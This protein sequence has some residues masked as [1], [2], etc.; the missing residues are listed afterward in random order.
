MAP[1]APSGTD[2]IAAVATPPGRGGVGVIRVSGPQSRAVAERLFVSPR[3]DFTGLRPYRLHHGTLRAPSGRT[4]DEAMAAFMPGPGS[5]TGEDTVELYCHG[6]P[7]VLTAVLAAV[8]ACGARPAGPGEFTKRA[9]QNGRLDL[10]QAEAVAELI[11][12]RGDAQ[13]DLALARLAG[14]MVSPLATG[15]RPE[16]LTIRAS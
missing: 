4:L 2:T 10:S 14:G 11:A 12:A 15:Y 9:F 1:A 3:P 16:S 8:F 7:A 6:S 13:A 5:Y